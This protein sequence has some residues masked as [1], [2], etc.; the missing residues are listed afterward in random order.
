[1]NQGQATNTYI[2]DQQIHYS[3]STMMQKV[4]YSE[5][6][7]KELFSLD[8]LMYIYIAR[9]INNHCFTFLDRVLVL[10]WYKNHIIQGTLKGIKYL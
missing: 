7:W 10:I 9:N 5:T 1:M 2:L 4:A 6:Q 3:G 8:K